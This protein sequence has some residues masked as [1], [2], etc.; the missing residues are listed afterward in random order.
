MKFSNLSDRLTG[1]PMFNLLAEAQELEKNGMN[2][3]HYEIGDQNFPSPECSIKE[4]VLAL[5]QGK[6]KY[7]NSSGIIELREAI[8][9]DIEKTHKFRPNINQILIAPAN[10]IIDLMIRCVANPGDSIIIPDPGFPTYQSVCGY[11]EISSIGVNYWSSNGKR[12]DFTDL[13]E[14]TD[15]KTKLII[16]NSPNNPMGSIISKRQADDIYSYA[17]ENEL[18]LL[19]DE[20][21]SKLIYS[22]THSSPS[23]NDEC[24][25]RSVILGSMSKI[26]SMSGWRIGYA[27]GPEELIKKMSLLFQTIFSCMP[28]FTQLGAAA[29]LKCSDNTIGKRL[30]ILKNRR[31]VLVEKLNSLPGVSCNLPD[32][33]IYAFPDIKGTGLS[34]EVFCKKM[35]LNGVCALPGD[36]FGKNGNDHIRFCFGSVSLK[37]INASFQRMKYTLEDNS[38]E[39]N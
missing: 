10:S 39:I 21:Y 4:L 37:E 28:E 19:S 31:N 1:Q 20:V 13:I 34:A 27:I 25:V 17:E 24:K 14:K 8:A 33:S 3:I 2:I 7:T 35:L 30:E 18:Y 32:G 15:S 23:I 12:F 36:Y 9:D 29:V 16:S 38:Y 26:Y 5:K 11:T 6:T 22:G